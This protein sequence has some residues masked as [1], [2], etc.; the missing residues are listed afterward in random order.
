MVHPLLPELRR[1]RHQ[2]LLVAFADD[3]HRLDRPVHPPDIG[4]LQVRGLDY[5]YAES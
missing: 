2:P 5:R 1:Q 3:A 4:P